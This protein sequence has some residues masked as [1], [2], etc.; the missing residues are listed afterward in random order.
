M[1]C[2]CSS[3]CHE[4]DGFDQFSE[5]STLF[6]CPFH[7]YLYGPNLDLTD[8]VRIKF[9]YSY[10]PNYLGC[11]RIFFVILSSTVIIG[12]RLHFRYGL[13]Y[14]FNSFDND[15]LYLSYPENYFI[16]DNISH[17]VFFKMPL[18]RIPLC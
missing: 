1:K 4:N 7:P 3:R 14:Y 12:A 2:H 6:L 13:K 16:D 18:P 17:F 15:S 9:R 11:F 8:I 5:V 10:N